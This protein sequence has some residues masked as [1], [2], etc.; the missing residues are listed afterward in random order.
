MIH[1]ERD[2]YIDADETSLMLV[3][4]NGKIDKKGRKVI[5]NR[6]YY[7]DYS[8][9]LA[10]VYKYEMIDAVGK[11]DSFVE[12]NDRVGKIKALIER[13]SDVIIKNY[14]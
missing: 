12:L 7:S 10:G 2:L 13:T 9:L 3:R 11:S 4:W 6:K 5:Q 8:S 1:I 14:N